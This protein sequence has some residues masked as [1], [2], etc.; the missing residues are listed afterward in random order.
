MTPAANFATK[1]AGV[2]GVNDTGRKF[3]TSVND[4]GGKQWEQ[5]SAGVQHFVS[6]QIQNL[7]NC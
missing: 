1:Y 4:T 6:D 3:V 2:V 7:Q 5:Y